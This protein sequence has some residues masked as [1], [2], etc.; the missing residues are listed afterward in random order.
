Q[1]P[2]G[3]GPLRLCATDDLREDCRGRKEA[4]GRRARGVEARN[5]HRGYAE[6]H[7]EKGVLNNTNL[8]TYPDHA[9]IRYHNALISQ[10]HIFSESGDPRIGRPL[11]EARLLIRSCSGCG[12]IAR[13]PIGPPVF[14]QEIPD[15]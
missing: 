12:I 6:S 10:T 13:F 1:L 4:N 14:L 3:D 11:A 8:L 2:D 9:T 5:P 7:P 15:A